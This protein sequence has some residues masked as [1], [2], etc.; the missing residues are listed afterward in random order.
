MN[1]DLFDNVFFSA[2]IRSHHHLFMLTKKAAKQLVS[3]ISNT[4]TSVSFLYAQYTEMFTFEQRVFSLS[5]LSFLL[6]QAALDHTQQICVGYFLYESFSYLPIN[7]NPFLSTFQFIHDNVSANSPNQFCPSLCEMIKL[8][9]NDVSLHFIQ[10]LT[11]PE[12]QHFQFP[13]ET[14]SNTPNSKDTKLFD[15]IPLLI[16]EEKINEPNIDLNSFLIDVLSTDILNSSF[17]LI[18]PRPLPEISP[19]FQEEFE[20][21]LSSENPPFLFDDSISFNSKEYGK[22]LLE[23]STREKFT[24]EDIQIIQNCIEKYPSI[25]TNSHFSN[26]QIDTMINFNK[27]IAKLYLSNTIDRIE[28]QEMIKNFD[29]SVTYV[30]IVQHLVLAHKLSDELFEQYVINSINRIQQTKDTNQQT[31]Q[32]MLFCRF[33]M[34]LLSKKVGFSGNMRIELH[35]FCLLFSNKGIQEAQKLFN[36]FGIN[37]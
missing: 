37:K 18:Y 15:S 10:D 4:N 27:E 29:V 34:F 33:I 11:V 26:S 19:F 7:D 16:S 8:L 3:L 24:Q 5:S 14:L 13:S 21:V 6:T 28:I 20:Y 22:V 30:E 17:E 1:L 2:L 12:I 9:L 23:K 35:S 36:L 32:V 25:I 31:C